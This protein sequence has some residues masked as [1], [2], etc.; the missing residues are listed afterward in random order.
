M[1]TQKRP[2]FPTERESTFLAD[3]I[4]LERMRAAPS[5]F[6]PYEPKETVSPREATPTFEGFFLIVC[7]FRYLT[8]LGNNMIRMLRIRSNTTNGIRIFIRVIRSYSLIRVENITLIYPDLNPNGTVR[9]HR[10]SE[11]VINIG[12]QSLERDASEFTI[13]SP[14]HSSATQSSC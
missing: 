8:F 3:S 10:S 14:T 1:R 4:W 2:V 12:A 9:H 13:F 11:G 6:N 5:D 7:H